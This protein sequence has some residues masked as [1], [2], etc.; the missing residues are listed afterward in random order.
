MLKTINNVPEYYPLYHETMPLIKNDFAIFSPHELYLI[1]HFDALNLFFI[2]R[3]QLSTEPVYLEIVLRPLCSAN[4]CI[5][6]SESLLSPTSF[7]DL[8][9]SRL[10]AKS[11]VDSLTQLYDL[12]SLCFFLSLNS[13]NMYMQ[14]KSSKDMCPLEIPCL[15]S[16]S[17]YFIIVLTF[18]LC[19]ITLSPYL[20]LNSSTVIK[21]WSSL[22]YSSLS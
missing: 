18:S 8:L 19:L 11:S 9:S 2:F 22:F 10:M 14:L 5:S 15:I 20:F 16:S 21:S 13:K 6:S 12:L 3:T 1:P 7:V 17:T 4:F